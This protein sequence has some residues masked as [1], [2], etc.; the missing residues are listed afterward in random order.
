M[1]KCFQSPLFFSGH[2]KMIKNDR[3]KMITVGE[4][5]GKNNNS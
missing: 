2:A 4:K 5:G 3:I 1:E